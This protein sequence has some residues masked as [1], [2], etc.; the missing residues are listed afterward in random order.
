MTSTAA[1]A[2]GLVIAARIASAVSWAVTALDGCSSRVSVR[3]ERDRG[4]RH[5][6][7]PSHCSV[8]TGPSLPKVCR[9]VSRR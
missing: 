5:G 7:P 8:H 9:F 6:T 4:G 3:R 2:V 1:I